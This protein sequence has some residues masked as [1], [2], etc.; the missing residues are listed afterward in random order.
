MGN[1]L[2]DPAHVVL[3]C[4]AVFVDQGLARFNRQDTGEPVN[5]R[6]APR[7]GACSVSF[8]DTPQRVG[9]GDV[10][11]PKYVL[12]TDGVAKIWAFARSCQISAM[13][14]LADTVFAVVMLIHAGSIGQLASAA[15]SFRP[16]PKALCSAAVGGPMARW[17]AAMIVRL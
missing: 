2:F 8:Y 16:P 10:V 15:A 14:F 17:S 5:R 11:R 3:S 13:S 9:E 6:D 1:S 12:G 4:G 7:Q